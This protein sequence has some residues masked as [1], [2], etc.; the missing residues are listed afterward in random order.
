MIQSQRRW[1]TVSGGI[2]FTVLWRLVP[3]RPPN[4]EPV[5]ATMMPFGK[6]MGPIVGLLFGALSM[7]IY[8]LCTSGFTQWT[9]VTAVTYGFIGAVAAVALHDRKGIVAYGIFAVVATLFYDAI[10]GVV[11]GALLFGMSWKDGF[12]G[13]IPF[14]INHLIGN[15]ILAIALSPVVEWILTRSTSNMQITHASTRK[16]SLR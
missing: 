16:P 15:V 1:L 5:L 12:V 11:A 8:D 7:V 9:V 2:L 4:V 14:T 3:F 13:Q 6:R 10:T